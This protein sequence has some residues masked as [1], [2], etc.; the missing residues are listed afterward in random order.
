MSFTFLKDGKNKDYMIW[1]IHLLQSLTYHLTSYKVSLLTLILCIP[2]VKGG[3]IPGD[4][5]STTV[6]SGTEVGRQILHLLPGLSLGGR[7]VLLPLFPDGSQWGLS[8]DILEGN[9]IT[10]LPLHSLNPKSFP[11]N[12]S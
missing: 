1:I 11:L 9:L 6:P 12:I 7:P 2:G 3:Q 5:N 4:Q 10:L 8:K